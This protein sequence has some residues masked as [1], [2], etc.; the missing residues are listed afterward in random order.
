MRGDGGL[1]GSLYCGWKEV[2]RVKIYLFNK[3]V[4]STEFGVMM[5]TMCPGSFLYCWHEQLG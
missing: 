5:R 3:A 1:L 4:E 2:D